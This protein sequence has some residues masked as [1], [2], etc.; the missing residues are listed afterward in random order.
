[1]G[2]VQ[3]D[4]T[5]TRSIFF[6]WTSCQGYFCKLAQEMRPV[7]TRADYIVLSMAWC[8]VRVG[9]FAAHPIT[10]FF[11]VLG[12]HVTDNLVASGYSRLVS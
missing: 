2:I 8:D 12:S 5:T 9:R 4:S 11:Q 6:D 7:R 3:D 1:M 10:D